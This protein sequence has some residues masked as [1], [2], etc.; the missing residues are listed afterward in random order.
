VATKPKLAKHN[1]R[2][3]QKRVYAIG[4]GYAFPLVA[5]VVVGFVLE[6]GFVFVF[7]AGALVAPLVALT[8]AALAAGFLA[9]AF[10]LETFFGFVAA[11]VF[12]V[13]VV[14]L[15]ETFGV[16]VFLTVDLEVAF[17]LCFLVVVL[18]LDL[19]A[20]SLV[21]LLGLSAVSLEAILL[22]F[23]EAGFFTPL[24]A[25]VFFG[26]SLAE[27]GFFAVTVLLLVGA[28]FSFGIL[29]GPLYSLTF[30]DLPFGRENTSP[31]PFAMARLRCAMFAAL[32][33]R[34]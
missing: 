6:V 22:E 5:R 33:S 28:G 13:A 15:E 29:D 12:L 31:S 2:D 18:F 20:A 24:E 14:F 32:G 25:V 17:T 1:T 23:S 8:A 34:P 16:A 19:S 27:D 30:P 11:E 26:F 10:L 9:S 3:K 7:D 4:E 21:I